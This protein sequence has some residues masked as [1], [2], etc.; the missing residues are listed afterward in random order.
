MLTSLIGRLKFLHAYVSSLFEINIV[1]KKY[2][3]IQDIY[4]KHIH[5]HIRT[6]I[7]ESQ[8]NSNTHTTNINTRHTHTVESNTHTRTHTHELGSTSLNQNTHTHTGKINTQYSPTSS[9]NKNTHTQKKSDTINTTEKNTHAHTHTNTET[10]SLKT[11]TTEQSPQLKI[12]DKSLCICVS[13]VRNIL[14][15][16]KRSLNYLNEIAIRE[17]QNEI[18]FLDIDG[19]FKLCSCG[20]N[21]VCVYTDIH[22]NINGFDK[23]LSAI[24]PADLPPRY[25]QPPPH[26]GQQ[27]HGHHM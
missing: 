24:I 25:E 3:N 17:K 2:T 14:T 16:L 7:Q 4:T 10:K 15:N 8:T 27:T 20:C 13:I 18:L 1:A 12:I 9:S 19:N 5:T 22:T 6:H 26:H 21:C 11:T 23:R